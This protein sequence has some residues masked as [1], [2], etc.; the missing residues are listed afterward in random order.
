MAPR[1]I[2]LAGTIVKL[3]GALQ[4]LGSQQTMFLGQLAE[5]L[6]RYHRWSKPAAYYD[7]LCGEWLMHFSHV[8]YAAYLDITAVRLL[9]HGNSRYS[10][11]PISTIIN[12]Q[13]S[14]RPMFSQQ[15]RQHAARLLGA[16]HHG[17]LNF[18]RQAI[19]F[20]RPQTSRRRWLK[21][22]IQRWGNLRTA[23]KKMHRFYFVIH[24]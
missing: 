7:L 4:L 15:L 18:A 3:T 5:L 11:F 8:V 1:F 16:S 14:G 17:N 20:V 2:T 21:F 9:R 10:D 13:R 23:R 24:T 22:G 19:A 12:G 6:N